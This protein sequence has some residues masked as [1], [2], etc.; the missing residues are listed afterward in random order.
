MYFAMLRGFFVFTVF[1]TNHC[2]NA[3]KIDLEQ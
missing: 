3:E 2:Y 1:L